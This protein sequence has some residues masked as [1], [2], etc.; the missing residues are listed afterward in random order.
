[1]IRLAGL[2]DAA[3]ILDIYG[4][5]IEAGAISFE[6][7]LPDVDEMVRRIQQILDWAPWLVW[8]QNQRVC[9][10]AYA[11]RHRE[12]AAYQ[13]S[14]DASVYIHPDCQR[15]G[16]ARKLYLTLFQLLKV[17]GFRAVHAGISLPNP[18]SVLLHQSLGFQPVAVYPKVGYKGGQWHNTGWWQ[19]EI[20]PRDSEPTPP[21]PLKEFSEPEICAA[22]A[23]SATDH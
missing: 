18:A 1:M 14:V 17:Q 10:Y 7:V 3:Q 6:T 11:C 4:P 21:R 15:Q 2:Q 12:R 19:L 13:W 20:G 16:L 5:I 9:G 8:E 22:I 23:K